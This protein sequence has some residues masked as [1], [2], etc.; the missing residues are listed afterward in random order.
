MSSITAATFAAGVYIGTKNVQFQPG[1]SVLKR[2]I[3]VIGTADPAKTALPIEEEIQ[4]F[5]PKDAESQTGAGSM[6][7]R[8]ITRVFSESGGSEVFI[9]AQA[10][11]GGATQATGSFDFTGSTVTA[12]G[13]L[14][15]YIAGLRVTLNLSIGDVEGDIATAL[16][17]AINA[18]TDLPATA[19]AALGVVTVTAKTKGPWGNDIDLSLNLTK[20][21][22]TPAGVTTVITTMTGGAGL[23]DIQTALDAMGTGDGQNASGFTDLVHGYGQDT[24]TA[25]ALSV[26][27]G[28]G[29]LLEGNFSK[30][31][32]R[33]FR[34][35][36]GDTTPG[37]GGLS[38][39]IAIGDSRKL[40]RTGG[41]IA[42]PGSQTHPQE[43]AAQVVGMHAGANNVTAEG[44]II[45][46]VLNGV[47]PGDRADQWT[48]SQTN[49]Q[50]ALDSGIS[51]TQVKGNTLTV[52]N[53][54]TFYHPDNVDPESNGYREYRNISLVQNINNAV[55]LTFSAEKW[56]QINIVENAALVTAT[57]SKKKTRDRNM[58]ID[59]L[60]VLITDMRDN[61]WLWNSS[62]S[63]DR[64]KEP[65]AVTNRT[66]LTGFDINIDYI[67]S[68]Q[69]GIFNIDNNFDVSIAI[70]Q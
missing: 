52:Q 68:G 40:D 70:L 46:R 44:N 65:G 54:V 38:A 36:V 42:V 10:E 39:L 9:M 27:N 30:T 14:A 48:S 8:L 67:F 26:Y 5:N 47:W 23:P 60:V 3:L 55:G 7:S 35:M 25:D 53:P 17:D 61:G 62:F 43:I 51:T 50:I 31:V 28:T 1:V 6:L 4:V 66:N 63:L 64:L 33:P 22:T 12:A 32:A 34:Y 13:T 59:D 57:E 24:T 20:G 29:N 18:K 15:A 41:I 19:V 16:A 2:K 37:T 56:Q 58:V 69:G 45:D 21:D 49:R 11:A